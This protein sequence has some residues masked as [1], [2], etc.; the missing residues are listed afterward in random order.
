MVLGS[1]LSMDAHKEREAFQQRKD[2]PDVMKFGLPD[3]DP[4]S[5]WK[6]TDVELKAVICGI[7]TPMG[8]LGA[9]FV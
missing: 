1:Y 3:R 5:A 9:T 7:P 6:L 2:W 8:W 4:V